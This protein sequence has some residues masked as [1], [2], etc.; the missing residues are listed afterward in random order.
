[1]TY[2][3]H[4]SSRSALIL[5]VALFVATPVQPSLAAERSNILIILADDK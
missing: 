4:A 1:M 5:T 2:L 3:L